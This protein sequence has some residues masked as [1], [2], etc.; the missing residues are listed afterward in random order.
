MSRITAP[1]ENM[2]TSALLFLNSS[3]ILLLVG[4]EY[5]VIS[6][7][8]SENFSGTNISYCGKSDFIFLPVSMP[9]LV[10]ATTDILSSQTA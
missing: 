6:G 3:A 5:H 4:S 7:V 8:S 1:S 9:F 10:I 2:H